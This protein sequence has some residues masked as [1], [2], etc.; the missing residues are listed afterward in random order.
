[1]LYIKQEYSWLSSLIKHFYAKEG[2][3]YNSEVQGNKC[4]KPI[5]EDIVV[6]DYLQNIILF[7]NMENKLWIF[8]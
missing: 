7:A 1:M 8:D 3:T 4:S 2:L 5:T 6:S